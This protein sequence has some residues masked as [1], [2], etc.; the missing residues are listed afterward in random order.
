MKGEKAFLQLLQPLVR[1][2]IRRFFGCQNY[3]TA[4]KACLD[5]F[6]S[7][8]FA[9]LSERYVP[10]RWSG[11]GYVSVLGGLVKMSG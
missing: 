7:C 10:I 3:A 1:S 6:T 11:D 5:I 2:T 8:V 4:S 9:L